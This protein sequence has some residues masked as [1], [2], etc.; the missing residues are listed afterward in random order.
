MMKIIRIDGHSLVEHA[1]SHVLPAVI[2]GISV[3]DGR[4]KNFDIQIVDLD[5]IANHKDSFVYDSITPLIALTFLSPEKA[6]ID[7]HLIFFDSPAIHFIQKP[8]LLTRLAKILTSSPK[9]FSHVFGNPGINLFWHLKQFLTSESDGLQKEILEKRIANSYPGFLEK[10]K[11]DL[12]VC[13]EKIPLHVVVSFYAGLAHQGG[14]IN[15]EGHLSKLAGA[16]RG[17]SPEKPKR[18]ERFLNEVQNFVDKT[19]AQRKEF[20]A[21]TNVFKKLRSMVQEVKSPVSTELDRFYCL[22]E[23]VHSSLHQL[24]KMLTKPH[25]SEGKWRVQ[26]QQP[27]DIATYASKAG[28][29]LRELFDQRK[30]LNKRMNG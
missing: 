10:Y 1:L 9:N 25:D 12:A 30:S 11:G 3:V 21:Q 20:F 6:A 8:F 13:I 7:P 19:S 29:K 23:K 17:Y 5:E 4:E 26:L 2:K 22:H 16:A 14:H 18:V 15:L 24:E 27:Q 28:K